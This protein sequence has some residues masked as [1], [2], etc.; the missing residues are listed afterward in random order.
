MGNVNNRIIGGSMTG[1]KSA[2]VDALVEKIRA[3]S[4]ANQPQTSV[5]E[6]ST[7]E[8]PPP[9]VRTVRVFIS[10]YSREKNK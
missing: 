8:V 6:S 3:R 7:Q 1:A 5:Q 4:E 9:G 10:S 2:A